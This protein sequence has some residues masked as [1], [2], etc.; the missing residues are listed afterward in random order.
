MPPIVLVT[1]DRRQLTGSR[2]G[3]KVRPYRPEVWTSERYVDA[4][5]SAGGIPLLVPPGEAPVDQLLDLADAV[6]LTGGDFD[7]HPSWYGE[8]VT[9]RIDRIEAGRTEIELGLARG[10]LDRG[11]PVLGICGGMQALA[12]ADGG[13]LVQDLPIEP[14][15]HE[16]PTDPAI[17]WHDV[18]CEG[19]AAQIFGVLTGANSTHHQAVRRCGARLH[20]CGWTSDGTIEVIARADGGFAL[21]VQWHPEVLGDDRPYRALIAAVASR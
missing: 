9:G 15:S 7:I 8:V 14:L 10:C 3:P 1:A 21:G 17:A 12:V 18:R 19:A 16:Q 2:P 13:T 4:V 5:R 11:L 6:V 20:A